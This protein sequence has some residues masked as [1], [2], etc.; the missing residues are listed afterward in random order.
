MSCAT[1]A[2]HLARLPTAECRASY[3]KAIV[4]LVMVTYTAAKQIVARLMDAVDP[5][6]VD[7]AR[8]ALAEVA[9][10]NTV[11]SVRLRWI[12]HGVPA[13]P[14]PPC[15]LT[16]PERIRPDQVT[17]PTRLRE[18]N[19]IVPPILPTPYQSRAGH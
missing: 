14:P 19:P 9:Q 18:D 17:R 13:W 4:A 10:V 8:T 2:G 3:V 12:G 16:P 5:A 7:Q 11:D 6:L 15:T 1:A